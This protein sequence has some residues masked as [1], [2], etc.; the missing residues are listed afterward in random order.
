MFVAEVCHGWLVVEVKCAG[1]VWA[2]TAVVPDVLREHQ[3][4]VPLT[5]DQYAR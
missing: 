1:T 3:T 4:Q 5:K 2:S